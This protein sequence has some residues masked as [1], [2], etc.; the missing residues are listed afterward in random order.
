M[1]VFFS[2]KSIYLAFMPNWAREL[3]WTAERLFASPVLYVVIAAALFL[4]WRMP[5]RQHQRLITRGLWQD[6]FWF[7]TNRI[8]WVGAVAMLGQATRAFYHA[9]LEFLTWDVTIQLPLAARIV[10]SILVFDFLDWVRHYVKHRVPWLWVFHAVHHS[11]REM[12]LFTEFRVHVVE[13]VVNVILLFIPLSMFHVGIPADFYIALVLNWY[14]ALYHANI[15]TNY[16][17]LKYILVTPQSHRLHHSDQREHVDMNFGVIFTFWDRLFGTRW[18][19]YDDYPSTGI[20]DAKFPNEQSNGVTGIF[21][22]WARQLAY[23]VEAL[24]R[25]RTQGEEPTAEDYR[26]APAITA[27]GDLGW[28]NEG[29]SISER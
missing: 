3:V 7:L 28:K 1:A 12:N 11:Q 25:T 21:G 27:P 29:R 19:D 24:Y 16:G 2:L 4:E 5:A 9:H 8:L 13:R 18:P 20:N 6:F 15:R 10:L 14:Q 22:T 23:P 17:P 26:R